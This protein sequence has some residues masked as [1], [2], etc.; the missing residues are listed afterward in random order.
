MDIILWLTLSL[1][2]GAA[3][4]GVW[5]IVEVVW[6]WWRGEDVDFWGRDQR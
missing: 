2:M 1:L 4:G 6:H 5:L 3:V